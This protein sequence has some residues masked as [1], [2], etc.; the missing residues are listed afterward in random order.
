MNNGA[1][2]LGDGLYEYR[3]YYIERLP[4][5]GHQPVRWI[6]YSVN[7]DKA[8]GVICQNYK[9]AKQ[10]IDMREEAEQ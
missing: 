1:H 6:Y 5:H 7:G 4:Q 10:N 2:L 9:T 8:H 3:G